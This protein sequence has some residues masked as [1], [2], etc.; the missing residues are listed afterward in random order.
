M[1]VKNSRHFKSYFLMSLGKLRGKFRV[2]GPLTF[3]FVWFR[4][5]KGGS[6]VLQIDSTE[7][8]RAAVSSN[9][10]LF[11]VGLQIIWLNF[12]FRRLN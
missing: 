6:K 3:S 1:V 10:L 12:E 2:V 4:S 7:A 8:S 9:G 11:K 5:W